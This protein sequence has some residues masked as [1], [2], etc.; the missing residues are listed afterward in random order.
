[1]RAIFRDDEVRLVQEFLSNIK[2]GFFVDVGA[3]DPT[4]GSQTWHLEQLG[5]N[6]IVIEPR[7]D[8][9]EKL[10]QSRRAKVYEVA[11]SSAR[12]RGT[13]QLNVKGG[14]S[15]LNPTMVVAGLRPQAAIQV[16]ARTLDEILA[17]AK[18]PSPIDFISIDVEGHEIEVLDGFDLA[19]WRPRLILVEDHVLDLRL[20][21]TLISRG[22]SWVRRTGLNGWYVPHEDAIEVGWLGRLQFF[23]KY[24]LAMPARR[25]R[26]IVRLARARL[27]ILPPQRP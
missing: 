17:D 21:R 8:C 27:G 16:D 3:A 12:N 4:I 1:M 25:I 9:A 18:A 26:D 14:Y 6:G 19:R 5:W 22:Y 7:P 11:C 23:R 13:A 10:R 20:H 2:N 15:T 24:Y